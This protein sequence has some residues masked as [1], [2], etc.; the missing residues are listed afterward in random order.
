MWSAGE[1]GDEPWG[2]TQHIAGQLAIVVL[3]R[4]REDAALYSAFDDEWT[5]I[6]RTYKGEPLYIDRVHQALG[7]HSVHDPRL[8][9]TLS[10]ESG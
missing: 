8:R 9:R 6:M 10:E 5:V 4:L 2:L 1:G 3:L 7:C